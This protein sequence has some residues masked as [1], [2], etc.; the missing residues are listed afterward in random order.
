MLNSAEHEISKLDQSNLIN[1]L[2][3]LL[4]CKDFHCFFQSF[5]FNLPDILKDKLS[6]KVGAPTQLSTDSS[7]ISSGPGLVW[8]RVK[9]K[10]IHQKTW[11]FWETHFPFV[12]V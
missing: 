11:L 3:K 5:K 10:M 1:L 4:T 7:F 2:K 12:M 6:F 8:E 9:I